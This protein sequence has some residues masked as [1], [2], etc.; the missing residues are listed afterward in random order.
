M[1]YANFV[2][3]DY[4]DVDSN[5]C[6]ANVTQKIQ[7]NIAQFLIPR[8]QLEDNWCLSDHNIQN[9]STLHLVIQMFVQK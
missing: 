7:D 4:I 5:D 1:R 2:K 9:E 6:I 3:E 8:V